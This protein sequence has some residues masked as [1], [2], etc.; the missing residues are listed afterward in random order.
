MSTRKLQLS[1]DGQFPRL[2]LATDKS[3][4]LIVDVLELDHRYHDNEAISGAE[5]VLRS[6]T[7]L[8]YRGQLDRNGKAVVVGVPAGK[9]EVRYGPDSRSYRPVA[10]K[11]NPVYGD[12]GW[13]QTLEA[14]LEAIFSEG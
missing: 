10:Q 7:G 11:K 14:R 5:F 1:A 13:N 9:L 3:H 6:S 12:E 2:D 8:E 4:V